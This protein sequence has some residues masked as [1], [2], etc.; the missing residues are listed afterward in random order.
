MKVIN[1]G[2]GVNVWKKIL[3]KCCGFGVDLVGTRL[4]M[5]MRTRREEGAT[6]RWFVRID[7]SRV[8]GSHIQRQEITSSLEAVEACECRTKYKVLS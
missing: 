7:K 8:S 5:M 6:S 2:V 1:S 4:V 3:K